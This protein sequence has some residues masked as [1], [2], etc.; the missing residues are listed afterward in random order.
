M[1]LACSAAV[2]AYCYAI[3]AHYCCCELNGVWP[4]WV[5]GPLFTCS[6]MLFYLPSTFRTA[7]ISFLFY[8]W[9]VGALSVYVLACCDLCVLAVPF[10]PRTCVVVCPILCT[11]H[12]AI[13]YLCLCLVKRK[14]HYCVPCCVLVVWAL[15]VVTLPGWLLCILVFIVVRCCSPWADGGYNLFATWCH[16][17]FVQSGAVVARVDLRTARSCPVC[18]FAFSRAVFLQHLFLNPH[19]SNTLYAYFFHHFWTLERLPLFTQALT[20]CLLGSCA[21]DSFSLIL[22]GD[23]TPCTSVRG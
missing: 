23:M 20:F 8:K 4:F 12:Y 22:Y 6:A 3:W 14:P 19:I 18:C 10:G 7:F 13:I 2:A 16:L 17:P 5:L 9:T 11:C 15:C 21:Y 1:Y